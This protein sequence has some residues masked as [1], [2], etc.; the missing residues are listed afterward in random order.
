MTSTTRGSSLTV[1]VTASPS[2]D[3]P[4]ATNNLSI[5]PLTPA[6][7]CQVCASTV[8]PL[9]LPATGRVEVLLCG[10]CVERLGTIGRS[11]ADLARVKEARAREYWHAR[12]SVDSPISRLV[13]DPHYW[14][15]DEAVRIRQLYA[16]VTA[17]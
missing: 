13:P 15:T 9:P 16:L 12:C 8:T 2:A 5:D 17:G 11:R 10:D 4:T 14:V 7:A 3:S 1:T 6:A